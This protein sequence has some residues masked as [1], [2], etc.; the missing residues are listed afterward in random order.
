MSPSQYLPLILGLAF[1]V[2]LVSGPLMVWLRYGGLEG[3][4]VWFWVKMALIVVVVL[5]MVANGYYRGRAQKG[6]AGAGRL[7]G[8]AAN[9]SRLALVGIVA[10][11]VLAFN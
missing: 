11:A 2:L 10:A 8:L 5:C 1:L 4:S 7:A 3:M 6:D 9:L